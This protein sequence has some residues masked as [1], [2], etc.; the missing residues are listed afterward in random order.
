MLNRRIASPT[1]SSAITPPLFSNMHKLPFSNDERAHS[2]PAH[3][4]LH[5]GTTSSEKREPIQDQ[6]RKREI[7][8]RLGTLVYNE[9]IA[10]DTID[11]VS[12]MVEV[13]N[14]NVDSATSDKKGLLRSDEEYDLEEYIRHWEQEALSHFRNSDWEDVVLACKRVLL[15]PGQSNTNFDI[16]FETGYAYMR[17]KEYKTAEKYFKGAHLIDSQR[18]PLRL[19]IGELRSKITSGPWTQHRTMW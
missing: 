6:K 11:K 17:M 10:R 13:G 9:A 3:L 15:V 1:S 8:A 16:L 7:N 4:L 12:N 18:V 2:Q 14:S 5:S 19:A